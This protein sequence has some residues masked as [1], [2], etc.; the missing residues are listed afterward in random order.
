[1]S[2][3]S[4]EQAKEKLERSGY[5]INK[6]S[7]RYQVKDSAGNITEGLTGTEVVRI[8]KIFKD[9]QKAMK[10]LNDY[11]EG[12]TYWVVYENPNS[13]EGVSERPFSTAKSRDDFIK[14]LR[15][16]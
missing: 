2:R 12:H 4:F 3:M 14:T 1:M 10:Y 8:A 15:K 16:E 7:G 9:E 6:K 5:E 11:K 13:I